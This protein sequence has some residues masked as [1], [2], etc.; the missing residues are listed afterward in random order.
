MAIR[1]DKRIRGDV[2]TAHFTQEAGENLE[3]TRV[4][5]FGNVQIATATEF[6]RGDNG[7]YFVKDELATL[8]GNVKV[9]RGENQM[10]GDKA[11]V[12]L[13]TG[14]S[15]MLGGVTGIFD[16]KSAEDPD[17]KKSEGGS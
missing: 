1:E 9:T 5:A 10:N 2:L 12:N 7:Q 4:D 17:E 16:P 15:K 14:V 6:A 3:L 13:R 8:T 11:E